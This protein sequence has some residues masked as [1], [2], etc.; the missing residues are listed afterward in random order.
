MFYAT[1]H[2]EAIAP[3]APWSTPQALELY[4]VWQEPGQRK[5]I[6]HRS[7]SATG[8]AFNVLARLLGRVCD[9]AHAEIKSCAR[10]NMFTC[11]ASLD[12]CTQ[13]F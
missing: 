7:A 11:R 8:R 10:G 4:S 12:Y 1:S 13:E 9:H 3:T 2:L 5:R 6:S